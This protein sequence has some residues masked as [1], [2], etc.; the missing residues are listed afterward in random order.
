MGENQ[1]FAILEWYV[2][3]NDRIEIVG[4][5]GSCKTTLLNVLADRY[6]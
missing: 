3:E 4:R 5:N 1:L 2:Y 6:A